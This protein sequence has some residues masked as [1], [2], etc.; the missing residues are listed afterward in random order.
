MT[1]NMLFYVLS[2]HY[3]Y[4]LSLH[5]FSHIFNRMKPAVKILV[6]FPFVVKLQQLCAA[7]RGATFV[8]PLATH[9]LSAL[10]RES[11]VVCALAH[12]QV[13]EEEE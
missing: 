9:V 4:H 6:R 10:R 5:N 8:V 2:Y 12:H 11:G 13:E 7:Q 3:H 1:M